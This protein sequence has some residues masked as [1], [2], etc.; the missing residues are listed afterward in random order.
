MDQRRETRREPL[1]LILVCAET[2]EP[3]PCRFD[4]DESDL[5]QT[6]IRP[7]RVDVAIVPQQVGIRRHGPLADRRLVVDEYDDSR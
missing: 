2:D 1:P 5:S 3:C 4:V 6:L 7:Q